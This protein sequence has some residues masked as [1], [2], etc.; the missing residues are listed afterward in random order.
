MTKELKF[1]YIDINI[2][3]SIFF[4]S[5]AKLKRYSNEFKTSYHVCITQVLYF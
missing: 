2:L 1:H 3:I 4:Y 5:K